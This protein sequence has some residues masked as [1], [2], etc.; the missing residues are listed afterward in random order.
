M[1]NL[2]Y[3]EHQAS[4]TN[5]VMNKTP[6]VRDRM[7]KQPHSGLEIFTIGLTLLLAVLACAGVLTP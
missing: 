3:T 7:E 2:A 6:R 4:A 1:K 5:C